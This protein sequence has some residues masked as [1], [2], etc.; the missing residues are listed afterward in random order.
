ML[1]AF[2]TRRPVLVPGVI[3]VALGPG[4]ARPSAGQL[5]RIA[6]APALWIAHGEVRHVEIADRP[7]RRILRRVIDADAEEG[8][9]VSKPA[10]LG[11]CH[12]AGV[13]PPFDLEIRVAG[14]IT[15]K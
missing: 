13:V 8:D 5:L 9:L 7:L 11:G 15:G 2:E 4:Q 3:R 10:A 12:V 6:I 14:V 1:L